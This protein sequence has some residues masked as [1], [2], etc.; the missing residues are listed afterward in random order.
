VV[1]WVVFSPDG[2]RV[3][4]A[5][6]DNSARLWNATKG[7]ALTPPLRAN[8]SVNRVAFSPDGRRLATA[9][10]DGTARVWDVA[11]L[12]PPHSVDEAD[13]FRRR[14]DHDL[15]MGRL[16]IP[17]GANATPRAGRTS[18]DRRLVLKIGKDDTVRVCDA[19][20][21]EPVAPPLTHRGEILYAAFSP[22][23]QRVVTT[24]ADQTAR[25]WDTANG[26]A[27]SPPLTHASAVE[28]ADFS[29]DGRRLVTA[30]DDNT[31]RIWDIASGAMLVPPLKHDGTVLQAIFSPNGRR[32]A[33]GG[34]DQT[35][36]VWDAA[37][38]QVLTPPLHHPWS[39]RQV[40]FSPDGQHLLTSGS[41]GLV[42]F[43]DL[44]RTVCATDEL[45]RFAQLLCGS[46][47]DENRGIMPL[48]PGE[49]KELW[50]SLRRTRSEFFRFS[51]DEVTA[52]HRQTAEECQRG[53]HES[54]A[55]WHLDRLLQ[56]E[57]DNWLYHARRGQVRAELAQWKE[58]SAD[59]AEVVRLAP[60][61]IEA[62]CLYAVLRLREGDAAGYRRACAAL[63]KQQ[64]QSDNPRIAY[65]TAWTCVLSAESPVKGKRLV[66][67]AK[68]A[69]ERQPHDP[70]YLATLGAAAFRAGDLEAAARRLKHA[71]AVRGRRPSP[72]EWLWLA[73]VHERRGRASEARKWLE[74]ADSPLSAAEA[75]ALPWVQRIQM[76]LLR[77]EVERLI[78]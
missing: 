46:R 40:R 23:G 76:E 16:S 9:S 69:V 65:L 29:P 47:I 32:V 52:W 72:R 4:T 1:H 31:A 28:F 70:D 33:T 48:A 50:T 49:L 21:G 30:S 27:A 59:F 25:V 18:P 60:Q 62:W 20:S 34:L 37:T 44:P 74:K 43:W 3:A 58:A 71:L 73:L 63:L 55:L 54:A 56:Q 17:R 51:A 68:Q 12:H 6:D 78:K 26:V 57:P 53:R 42:W 41:S 45:V 36:R 15:R 14:A 13:V 67:L 5:G 8:G 66:D 64:E 61:E 75:D 19:H 38:G 39:V 11:C 2:C 22:D 77:R 35:A 24:S 7:A 10:D